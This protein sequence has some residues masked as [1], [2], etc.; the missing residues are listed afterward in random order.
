MTPILRKLMEWLCDCRLLTVSF[1]LFS[2]VVDMNSSC[3]LGN[4]SNQVKTVLKSY[5][6]GQK[7]WGL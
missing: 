3:C 2:R 5:R 7:S 4:P 1:F 6:S